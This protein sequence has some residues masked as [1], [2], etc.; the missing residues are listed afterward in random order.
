MKVGAPWKSRTGQS[1]KLYRWRTKA[2]YGMLHTSKLAPSLDSAPCFGWYFQSKGTEYLHEWLQILDS[3]DGS[4]C[5]SQPSTQTYSTTIRWGVIWFPLSC[6]HSGWSQ[7]QTWVQR[8]AFCCYLNWMILRGMSK[9]LL[10]PSTTT[11]IETQSELTER[12]SFYFLQADLD[13]LIWMRRDSDLSGRLH[14]RLLFILSRRF[15]RSSR[16][17][18]G[19]AE[20]VRACV[21][22]CTLCSCWYSSLDSLSCDS[23]LWSIS[24]EEATDGFEDR[25]EEMGGRCWDSSSLPP[26]PC[27]K[28]RE[29]L[30]SIRTKSHYY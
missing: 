20:R 3:T 9:C 27:C 5:V 28:R 25:S 26:R 30:I 7:V 17:A 15:F 13:I 24:V 1:Q 16:L 18:A 21:G 22:E 23:L 29:V 11:W 10:F 4:Y 12:L 8:G 6:R 2:D 14:C 19:E